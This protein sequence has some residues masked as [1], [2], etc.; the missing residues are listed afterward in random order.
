[1]Q[2]AE[3]SGSSDLKGVVYNAL[4]QVLQNN[5]IDPKTLQPTGS[6]GQSGDSSGSQ[7]VVR[8]ATSAI[9]AQVL[10]AVSSA[11]TASNPLAQLTSSQDDSQGSSDLTSLL[12]TSQDDAGSGDSLSQFLALDND[13]QGSADLTSLLR[14]RDSPPGAPA[15]TRPIC[16]PHSSLPKITTRTCSGFYTIQGNEQS[17]NSEGADQNQEPTGFRHIQAGFCQASSKKES[18]LCPVLAVS[19]VSITIRSSLRAS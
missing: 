12:S 18:L 14:P 9:L 10:A 6:A 13:S 16:F 7:S 8:P 1:M 17:A 19:A 5:G 4:V 3:Q 2:S 11:S 15:R